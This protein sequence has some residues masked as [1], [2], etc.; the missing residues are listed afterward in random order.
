MTQ[1]LVGL[2]WAAMLLVSP[3]LVSADQATYIYDDLG[4]LSQ[5]IDGQGNVATYA[6]DAVGNPLSIARS[7]GGVGAPT[8]TAFTPNSG[9][10]GATVTV[11]LTGTNLTGASLAT[12]NP[13]IL[14]RN[15][16]TPP[17]LAATFYGKEKWDRLLFGKV[18]GQD[19]LLGWKDA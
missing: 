6:Y 1:L 13:G 5:V 7:T 10:A 9:N 15:V 14:V 17:P 12:N 19:A 16:L 11:S 2:L 3:A 18:R 8:I 4:R